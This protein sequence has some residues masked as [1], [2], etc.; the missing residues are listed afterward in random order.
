MGERLDHRACADLRIPDAAVGTDSDVVRQA[1]PA[2]EDAVDIDLDITAAN[3]LAAQIEAG[4]IGQS[5]PGFHQLLGGALLEPAFQ[6]RQLQRAVD[7]QHLGFVSGHCMN[8]RHAVGNRHRD[9][10]GQVILA[11]AI[12]VGQPRQP[13]LQL[14]GRRRHHAGIHLAE[15]PLRL[16][17]VLVFD[18][19]GDLA[20]RIADDPAVAGRVGEFDGQQRQSFAGTC[21]QQSLGG[22]AFD[23]RHIAIQD[24]RRPSVMQQRHRLLHGMAGAV[25]WHL[26]DKLDAGAGRLRLDL[27]GAMPRHDDQALRRQAGSHLQNMLQ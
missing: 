18:D 26:A 6:M 16:A 8:H 22:R 2:F 24:Q 3:Q 21:R 27:V 17:G 23:Q 19:A 7:T 14:G 15:L 20:I 5:D 4:R 13:L 12:V 25:L 11:L 1:D 9:D 10:I